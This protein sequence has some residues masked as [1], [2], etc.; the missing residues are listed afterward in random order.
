MLAEQTA[1]TNFLRFQHP[2]K[3]RIYE[4]QTTYTLSLLFMFSNI[5]DIIVQVLGYVA[6]S[7]PWPLQAVYCIVFLLNAVS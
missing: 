6:M 2:V 4:S 7:P 5:W 3:T 1:Y